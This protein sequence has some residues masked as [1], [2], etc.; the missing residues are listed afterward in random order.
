MVNGESGQSSRPP[1]GI[2][3]RCRYQKDVCRGHEH[4]SYRKNAVH[5]ANPHQTTGQ[6]LGSQHG[7]C[8]SQAGGG[9]CGVAQY[10]GETDCDIFGLVL[11]GGHAR[12]Y[13]GNL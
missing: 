8:D 5:H 13:V 6:G 12:S 10:T 7:H 4:R 2:A 1:T 3:R 9:V 11:T